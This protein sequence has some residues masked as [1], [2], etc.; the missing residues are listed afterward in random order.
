MELSTIL[1]I[2]GLAAA[3]YTGSTVSKVRS[4]A[5][6]SALQSQLNAAKGQ[7]TRGEK[8]V[9]PKPA[10]AEKP[11]KNE[12]KQSAKEAFVGNVNKFVPN[13]NTLLDGT[14]NSSQWTEIIVDINN[15]ELTNLW[16]RANKKSD[17]VLRI[18][19]MWGLKPEYCTSFVATEKDKEMYETINGESIIKG[20]KYVVKSPCWILTDDTQ[21][22]KTIV[23]KGIVTNEDNRFV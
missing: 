16:K 20:H 1:W 6:I 15:D 7:E 5:E 4:K 10:P 19:G 12:N 13:L 21:S 18:F 17:N 2:C 8:P 22:K 23:L 14:Y 9:T 11:Y 3:Y